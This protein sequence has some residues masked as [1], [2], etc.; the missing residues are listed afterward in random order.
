MTPDRD[1]LHAW[2]DAAEAGAEAHAAVWPTGHLGAHHGDTLTP[3]RLR[4]LAAWLRGL[5]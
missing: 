2:A 5:A 3:D 1:T 4:E